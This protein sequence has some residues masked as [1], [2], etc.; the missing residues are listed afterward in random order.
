MMRCGN[1]ICA[2]SLDVRR[3]TPDDRKK[4]EAER[5]FEV[6]I[7]GKT[8]SVAEGDSV[9]SAALEAGFYIPHLCHHPRLEGNEPGSCRLCGVE[10]NGKMKPACKTRMEAGMEVVTDSPKVLDAVKSRLEDL[11]SCHPKD[12]MHCP[13]NGDCEFQDLVRKY[14]PNMTRELPPMP[15]LDEKGFDEV[16]SAWRGKRKWLSCARREGL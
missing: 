3:F 11:V 14:E 4:H 8:V 6:T 16:R 5:H 2:L 10:V 15:V 1:S 9:L 12:C 7:N 13:V